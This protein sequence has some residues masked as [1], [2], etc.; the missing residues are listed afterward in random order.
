MALGLFSVLYVASSSVEAKTDTEE[1]ATFFKETYEDS[2]ALFLTNIQQLQKSNPELEHKTWNVPTKTQEDLKMDTLYLPPKSG[3]KERLLILTSGIHGI[4]GFVGS[5]LQ[6]LFL[7]EN[8]WQMRDENLG[9][10]IVHAMS[11]YG[12]KFARRV[13]ENNVDL[14][15]N[16][17]IGPD[18]FKIK[19]E[20]YLQVSPLL[21]PTLAAGS[22]VLDRLQF[23][24]R[25][26]QEIVKYSMESLR[27][28]ILKGQYQ[29]PKGIY[30]G[31]TQFEPQKEFLEK[32]FISKAKDYRQILLVDLHTGYGQRGHLHL[33]ADRAPELDPDYLAKIFSGYEL[34]Y[35]QKKYFYAATGGLVVYGAKLFKNTSHYA[36]IVFEFGTLN[37]QTTL[38][39]LDSLYR[40]VR[41]N[42]RFH[43]GAQSKADSEEINQHFRE[44]FYPTSVEWRKAVA[45]QFRSTL[46]LA[47]KNQKALN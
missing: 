31:G 14:N 20:A 11:P 30:F 16:F 28:A 27:R 35:G 40:M 39:S 2:R 22:G 9:I 17:D 45:T 5:A 43:Y 36:G 12:F 26:A 18:L 32:E 19:N 33:F 46:Q 7:K 42:Q 25:C 1:L 6:N 37:S 13:T 38:G 29:E 47:L 10:L 41:E 44:M 8:F 3:K 34:D 4:E 15:R 24:F 21:N 23:Y